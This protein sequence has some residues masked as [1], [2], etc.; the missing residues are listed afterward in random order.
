MGQIDQAL[1][2]LSDIRAHLATTAQFRGFA[3]EMLIFVAVIFASVTGAQM[4]WPERLAKNDMSLVL[5]WGCLHLVTTAAA[6]VE[7][8]IRAKRLHAGMAWSMWRSAMHVLGSIGATGA[9]ITLN[10]A[11]YAPDA[12]W[13][14]PGIWLLLIGLVGVAYQRTMPPGVWWVALLYMFLGTIM[15]CIAGQQGHLTPGL[16]GIPM[17]LGNLATALILHNAPKEP[18]FA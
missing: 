4:I 6:A 2:D 13:I 15:L 11:L 12:I 1:A 16:I 7:A 17:M 10:I 3:P 5:I 14:A 18:T 9:I 8:M